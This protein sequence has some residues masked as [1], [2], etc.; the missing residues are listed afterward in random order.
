MTGSTDTSM[1]LYN[2]TCPNCAHEFEEFFGMNDLKA[3]G[4]PQCHAPA[5]RVY[6]VFQYTEDRTR[7]F[8]NPVTGD[9]HSFMLGQP[10]P[11]SRREFHKLCEQKG[12]EPVSRSSMPKEWKAASE[13]AR[14]VK[15]GGERVDPST[16]AKPE[17]EPVK[18]VREMVRENAHKFRQGA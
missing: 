1:P 16:V 9:R 2:F 6:T 10:M 14:H 13:Y 7:H 5:R 17:A 8:R 4:C 11:E 15:S 12:I 18:S 3:P